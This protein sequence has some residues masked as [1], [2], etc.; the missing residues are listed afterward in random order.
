MGTNDFL[1]LALDDQIQYLYRHGSFVTDIRYYNY[2]VNLYLLNGNYLEVF[3]NNKFLTI[4]TICPLD[5]NSNRL[6]FYL[7]QIKLPIA[8]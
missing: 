3:V 2:K 5:F 4:T 8:G 1:R 7:D 6:N